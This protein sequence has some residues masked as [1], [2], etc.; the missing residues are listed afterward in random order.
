[1]ADFQNSTPHFSTTAPTT[2]TSNES[3]N[4][5]AINSAILTTDQDTYIDTL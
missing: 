4:R 5:Q 3:K 1:M 2:T